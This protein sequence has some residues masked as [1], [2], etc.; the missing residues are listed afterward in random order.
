MPHYYHFSVRR[1]VFWTFVGGVLIGAYVLANLA[2]WE[3]TRPADLKIALVVGAIFWGL[4]ALVAWAA[5]G[6]EIVSG[7]AHPNHAPIPPRSHADWED[8]ARME[9]M[10]ARAAMET[11]ESHPVI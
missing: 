10:R 4:F 11:G 1:W 3:Q 6:V 2:V 7:S 5:D 8:R 9:A